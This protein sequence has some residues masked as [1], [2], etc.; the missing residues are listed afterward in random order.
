VTTV[1][2]PLSDPRTSLPMEFR[3]GATDADN[4]GVAN[5]AA[6]YLQDQV[7]LSRRLQ[8]IVGLRYDRFTVDFRHN[9]TA[10]DLRSEDNLVSPRLGLVYKPTEP[11][12]VYASYSLS[13]LPRAGEQLASLSPTNEALDPERFRNYELGAKWDLGSRLSLTGAAYRLDRENVAVPDPLNPASS[14]LV[15]A[16]RTN[17]VELGVNGSLTSS[18]TV[19]GGYAYQDGEITQSVSATAQEGARLAQLP[20]HTFS[21]W[22]RYDFTQRLGV[23]L[24]VI[25]RTEMFTSTDNT[26]VLPGFTRVDAAAYFTLGARLQAQANVENVFDEEYFSSA[27]NN[28][29][30]SPGSPRALRVALTTRF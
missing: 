12:S 8:A 30:I 14:I 24:G 3:P 29:N 19:L 15:D 6:L 28:T 2:A 27:H 22:N 18:W 1:L 20:E 16:Q 25:H 7:A 10:A 13:Y 4:H 17:G 11:V 23:A 26:V 21:L 9:R 5:V